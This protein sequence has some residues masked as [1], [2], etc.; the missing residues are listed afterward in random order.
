MTSEW[1]VYGLTRIFGPLSTCHSAVVYA[2]H[3]DA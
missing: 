3:V 2:H 1:G